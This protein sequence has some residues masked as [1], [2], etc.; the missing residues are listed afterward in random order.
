MSKKAEKPNIPRATG[1][2]RAQGH[3]MRDK[4]LITIREKAHPHHCPV[5]G[6]II[7]TFLHIDPFLII[8][9]KRLFLPC[10]IAMA[11]VAVEFLD[12]EEIVGGIEKLFL[13]PTMAVIVSHR[14]QAYHTGGVIAVGDNHSE[15]AVGVEDRMR[16]L[17][18]H[19]I[20][21]QGQA[22]S[23]TAQHTKRRQTY[24]PHSHNSLLYFRR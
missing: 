19:R 11:V 20:L 14:A 9:I 21:A 7:L 8:L 12:E 1:S 18:D 6:I 23:Q 2:N 13:Y 4:I 10:H 24:R 3:S 15:A 5:P 17:A 16:R 22:G